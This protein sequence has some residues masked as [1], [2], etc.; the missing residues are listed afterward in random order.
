MENI[1][2]PQSNSNSGAIIA[3]IATVLVAI[4]GYF[5]ATKSTSHQDDAVSTTTQFAPTPPNQAGPPTTAGIKL[6]PLPTGKRIPYSVSLNG[7]SVDGTLVQR[8][9]RFVAAD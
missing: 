9:D 7:V 5:A 8:S 3:A 6:A 1:G 4:I 2:N